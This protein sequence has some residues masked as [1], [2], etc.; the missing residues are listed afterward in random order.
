ML[1]DDHCVYVIRYYGFVILSL[2]VEDILLIG[3]DNRMVVDSKERLSLNFDIKDID[4][5]SCVL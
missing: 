2:Y 5:A 4:K 3:N 1:E